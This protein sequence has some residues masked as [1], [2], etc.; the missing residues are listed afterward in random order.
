MDEIII[1][2][3]DAGSDSASGEAHDKKIRV[4]A[5]ALI[6]GKIL[7]MPASTIYGISCRYDDR[8]AVNRIYKIKKRRPDMPFII[9]ISDIVQLEML[10]KD[11][12]ITAKRFI[13][14]YWETKKPRPL[15]LIFKK[16]DDRDDNIPGDLPTI[17]VR[18]AGLKVIRDI[19][20]LSGPI[21][22]TSATISGTS[23]SP[24]DISAVPSDIREHVDMVVRLKGALKGTESTIVDITGRTPV[25]IRKGAISFESMIRELQL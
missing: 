12:N 18:M 4:I 19:I 25:L 3:T 17:A 21:I 1:S 7:V 20:D 5:E 8:K 24:K 13:E 9:L 22:S 10:V 14:R 15:T 23:I 6:S 2:E 16:S 11:L